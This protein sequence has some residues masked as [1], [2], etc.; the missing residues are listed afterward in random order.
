VVTQT[1]NLDLGNY[2]GVF[3][4][5]QRLANGNYSFSSGNQSVPPPPFA[6]D[7]EFQPNGTKVYVQ[8]LSKEEYRGWRLATLYSSINPPCPTC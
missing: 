7:M 4:S 6:Q 3:G 5:A 8:Q 1:V 2:S